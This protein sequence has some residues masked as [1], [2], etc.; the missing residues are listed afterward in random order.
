MRSTINSGDDDSNVEWNDGKQ[1]DHV[2]KAPKGP[3]SIN[4]TV[5]KSQPLLSL[6][7]SKGQQTDS[8]DE[9]VGGRKEKLPNTILCSG[10]SHNVIQSENDNGDDLDQLED[11]RHAP[12]ALVL[13]GSGH[14]EGSGGAENGGEYESRVDLT[15]HVVR[16][17]GHDVMN[18]LRDE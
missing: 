10:N 16:G 14:N 4:I 17:I 8:W 9:R 3:P 5:N 2:Q 18:N 12:R 11:H 1:V 6:S 15:P 13:G 7:T